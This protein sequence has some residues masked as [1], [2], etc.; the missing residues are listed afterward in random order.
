M[1]F[2]FFRS[3]GWGTFWVETGLTLHQATVVIVIEPL[4]DP[5]L[6]LQIPKRA[7]RLGQQ[8]EMWY[9]TIRT[10]TAIEKMVMK[11]D[12]DLCYWLEDD[13]SFVD[14]VIPKTQVPY[15]PLASQAA[16]DALARGR[17]EK[18]HVIIT[19]NK[20]LTALDSSRKSLE[21]NLCSSDNV[22]R[23]K[24]FLVEGEAMC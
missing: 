22:L 14:D 23:A 17:V 15:T 2:P 11:C 3:R 7:Q 13:C 9:Y 19:A 6:S 16:K 10:H 20:Q 12:L 24:V 18:H 4:Y 5:N 21:G 8:K 1:T